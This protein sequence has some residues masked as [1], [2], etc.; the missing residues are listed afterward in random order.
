M[1]MLMNEWIDECIVGLW[2]NVWMN[3]LRV[4]RMT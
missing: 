1:D 3:L 2:M 4:K